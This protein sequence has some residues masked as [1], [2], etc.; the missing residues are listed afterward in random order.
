VTRHTQVKDVNLPYEGT[1]A[2]VW[3]AGV[4]LFVMLLGGMPFDDSHDG[5]A[6]YKVS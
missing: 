4:M 1:K 5:V 3:S 6:A 2:D